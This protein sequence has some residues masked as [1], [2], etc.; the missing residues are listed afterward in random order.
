MGSDYCVRKFSRSQIVCSGPEETAYEGGVFTATIKFPS[1]Y[2]LN[3]PVSLA[4][5][6]D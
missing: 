6:F 4:E 5:S 2:P 1:D 3:P